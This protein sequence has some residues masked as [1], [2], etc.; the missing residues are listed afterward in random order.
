MRSW[1][2]HSNETRESCSHAKPLDDRTAK[3]SIVCKAIVVV[4]RSS[5][6]CDDRESLAGHSIECEALL[7]SVAHDDLF[8]GQSSSGRLVG[9]KEKLRLSKHSQPAVRQLLE[10]VETNVTSLLIE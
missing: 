4:Y 3:S 1:K 5:I 2:V 7:D 6:V 8:D 10:W 9:H